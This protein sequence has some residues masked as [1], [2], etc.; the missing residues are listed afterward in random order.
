MAAALVWHPV[1]QHA[2]A[3]SSRAERV[4]HS[5]LKACS[6]L[7]SVA[8]LKHTSIY[9]VH[10]ACLQALSQGC[11]SLHAQALAHVLRQLIV[12]G[13]VVK[14][15]WQLFARG[16]LSS[17]EPFIV[18]VNAYVCVAIRWR[19]SSIL[20]LIGQSTLQKHF[21]KQQVPCNKFKAVRLLR[22]I[23]S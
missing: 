15:R 11:L 2:L 12:Y 3:A 23:T 5:L 19:P 9:A 18:F 17:I 21:V 8:E 1:L 4:T 13:P 22:A 20:I 16:C 14:R 10:S 7:Q 6:N